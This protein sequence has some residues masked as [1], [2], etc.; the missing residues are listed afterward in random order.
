MKPNR[1]LRND[2]IHR[3]A[4]P[5]DRRQSK[6]AAGDSHA[7]PTSN[8]LAAPETKTILLVSQ[9]AQLH[10]ELRHLANALGRIVVRV[11]VPAGA[12]P[13]LEAVAPAAVLLDLDLPQEASW[14]TAELLLQQP[15]CPPLILLTARNDKFD[16]RTAIR[17]GS[18]VDKAQGASRLLEVVEEIL[19]MPGSVQAERNGIQRV[20]IR[21]LKP[22][23]W[24]VPPERLYRRW[25]I[26]E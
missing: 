26:S 3:S 8:G 4:R 13:V 1:T 15:N 5:K 20:L 25:R 22:S 17:A 12:V 24:P 9:D 19:A 14:R 2:R 23:N 11:S 10:E 21:W 18:L 16:H 7:R 6:P